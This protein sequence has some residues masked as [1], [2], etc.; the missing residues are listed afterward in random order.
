[1]KLFGL[2][3]LTEGGLVDK[4]KERNKFDESQVKFLLR[5]NLRLRGV[6][7]GLQDKYRK[8]LKRA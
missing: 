1:M 6:V 2:Y 5:D 7:V 4:A 3:I 8:Y